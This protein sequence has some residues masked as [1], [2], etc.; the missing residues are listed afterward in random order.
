MKNCVLILIDLQNDYF[1]SGAHPLTHSQKAV[2]RAAEILSFARNKR[3]PVIHIRHESVGKNAT[4]MLPRSAGAEIH[5]LVKP[6]H[7]ETVF[8]KHFPNSFKETGLLDVLKVLNATKLIVCGMMTHMCVD[9]TVRAA[10]DYGFECTLIG[11]ACAT[12]KL[13]LNEQEI[14]SDCVHHAF[15]AALSGTYADIIDSNSFL[16]KFAG[17]TTPKSTS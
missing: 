15:L 14:D 7:N 3:I 13:Q 1:E 10:S 17:S 12:R 8:T 5:P 11:D 4:F 2:E 9:A 16:T 6:L